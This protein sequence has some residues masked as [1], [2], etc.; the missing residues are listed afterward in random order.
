MKKSVIMIL[1]AL[2]LYAGATHAVT[3]DPEDSLRV[4]RN[5]DLDEVVVTAVKVSSVTPVAYGSLSKDEMR[6]RDDGQG[7]P[8]LLSV[9]PSVV[10]TSD[11]GTGIGYAG[12]RIR[13]ADATRV[14]VTVNGVPVNDSESHT[15]FWVNMPDFASSVENIQVQ[16]GAGASVNGAGAFGGTVAMQTKVPAM[17]P[18]AEYTLAGGSFGTFRNTVQG[19][20][21][22]LPGGFTADGRFS[23]MQSD[24]YIDRAW[25]RMSSWYL[26]TAWYGDRTL[27]RFQTFGSDEVTYQAW[28]GVPDA[29]LAE[30]IRTY[31][32]CGEYTEGGK[33][34]FYDNQTDNY[35]QQHYHLTAGQRIGSRWDMNLTLHY[36]RGKGYYEDYK[37]GA[38]YSAYNLAPYTDPQGETQSRTDL[39]RRKWLDNDF[40]GGVYSANYQSPAMRL[41]LGLSANGYT[42][43]HFGRVIWAKAANALPQP[44]YEYYRS[45][46]LKSD[47]SGFVKLSKPFL[48]GFNAYVDLQYRGIDYSMKGSDDKAGAMLDISKRWSFFNPKAGLH[49]NHDGHAAYLSFAVARREPTRNNFTEAA[50]GER[51]THETLYDYEAGYSWRHGN[52]ELGANLYYMRYE[53]QLILTGKISEIGEALTSNIPDSYRTGLELTAAARIASCLTWKGNL[54]LSSNKILRFTEYVDN[55]DTGGQDAISLGT[56]DIA[57]SPPV[58]ANSLFDFVHK[59]FS[60]SLI[61]QYVGRQYLDNTASRERSLDPWFVSNLRLGYTFALPF[62]ESLSV[63][64]TVYNLLNEQYESNGWVYSWMSD[65]QRSTDGGRFAQAGTHCLGRLTLKF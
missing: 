29:M 49:Y 54:T 34:K 41:S 56:T 51:P 60:A 7:V 35:D 58:T 19:S 62:A 17:K 4:S 6:K 39:V 13:G 53:N 12:F 46:S 40:Y 26:S 11:A 14:N 52:L 32:P 30:G 61:T 21:G 9:L 28:N 64:F 59:G 1:C 38:K 3:S 22:L 10:M 36:T 16:R 31:N 47:Y 43:R 57:F 15:V 50:P 27:I 8:A 42:G 44:D 2:S 18:S 25:A 5:I 55:Y 63:D 33:P 24:G 45:R 48:D 23:S 20:T 37:A 65:G